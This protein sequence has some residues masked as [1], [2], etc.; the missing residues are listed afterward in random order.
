MA[1]RE[2][3]VKIRKFAVRIALATVAVAV[4]A[5]FFWV[6]SGSGEWVLIRDQDGIQVYSLKEPGSAMMKFRGR[7]RVK[8]SLTSSVFLYR[9]DPST[10]DDFGGKNFR[11]FDKVETPQMYLSYFSVEQ[12][13]PPPLGTKEMVS[14]LNYAQDPKTGE[15]LINVQAAPS[16]TPPTPGASRVTLLNNQFRLTPMGNGEVQWEI[17]GEVDLGL[18][19]PLTNLAMPELLFKGLSDQRKLVL[20]P[21]YQRARLISVREPGTEG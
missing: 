11:I 8:T 21:K 7:T 5:H 19:Y 3:L 2:K 13:L 18:P 9:G 16:A 17:T 20:T 1:I 10:N 12:P 15:V 6:R 14:M 4:C